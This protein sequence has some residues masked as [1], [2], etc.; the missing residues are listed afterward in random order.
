MARKKQSLRQSIR[1]SLRIGPRDFSLL[2]AAAVVAALALALN[3]SI[4]PDFREQQALEQRLDKLKREVAETRRE[5]RQLRGEAAA[6]E[7]PY[8][9]AAWLVERYHWRYPPPE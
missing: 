4:L 5:G 9:I 8:Y 3:N 1:D 2:F 7:D 6:L